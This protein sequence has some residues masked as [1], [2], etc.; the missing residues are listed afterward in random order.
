MSKQTFDAGGMKIR[1]LIEGAETN[2]AISVFRC[3]FPAGARIPL[4]HS[5]DGFDETVVVL[6][7]E[8]TMVVDGKP[9]T[10]G[11]GESIHVPRGVV[12]GFAVEESASILAISTPGIFSAQYFQ[13]MEDAMKAMGDGPP[14][15]RVFAQ[16][17]L[18]HGLTPVIP[19]AA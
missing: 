12:H 2:D 13:D 11:A 19:A 18:R 7:G 4:A 5:H 6:E 17:M 3:D 8:M 10:L 16:I 14:D 15:R 9:H 1:F